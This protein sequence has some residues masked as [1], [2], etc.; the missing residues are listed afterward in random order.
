MH[1]PELESLDQ[2][3]GGDLRLKVIAKL[4]PSQAAFGLGVLGLLSCGDVILMT[5]DGGQI[6]HWRWRELFSDGTVFQ[7][8]DGLQLRITSQGPRKV[9]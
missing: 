8:L 3:L 1:S 7:Q 5:L 6:P 9:A 2:L 4:F